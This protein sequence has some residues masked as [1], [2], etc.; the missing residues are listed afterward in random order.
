MWK[1]ERETV[2]FCGRD[3]KPRGAPWRGLASSK[4]RMVF[5]RWRWNKF[6]LKINS[7]NRRPG[8]V[9]L[10]RSES[11]RSVCDMRF[12]YREPRNAPCIS[13]PI[14][15]YIRARANA[16]SNRG[17]FCCADAGGRYVSPRRM[18][19]VR[20]AANGF[21]PRCRSLRHSNRCHLLTDVKTLPFSASLRHPAALL[22][23]CDT[24]RG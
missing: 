1:A 21:D 9:K 19:H 20:V 3:I 13:V 18:S 8:G 12:S 15:T 10:K 16:A 6:R 24:V 14:R 17:C 7:S 4:Y 2:E 22:R 11:S 5:G 23:A